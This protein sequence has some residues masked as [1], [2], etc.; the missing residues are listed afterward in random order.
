MGPTHN[1]QNGP[2]GA[3]KWGGGGSVKITT[4]GAVGEHM[5]ADECKQH[6][7][8]HSIARSFKPLWGPKNTLN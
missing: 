8:N 1:N 2:G 4:P 5:S 6:D 3:L 7:C